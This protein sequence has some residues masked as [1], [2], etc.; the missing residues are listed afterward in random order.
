MALESASAEIV[1]SLKD[2]IVKKEVSKIPAISEAS[3][4]P[5]EFVNP[6]ENV[7][8]ISGKYFE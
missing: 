5:I 4:Y 6:D 1:E 7:Y 2:L 3:V 8:Q